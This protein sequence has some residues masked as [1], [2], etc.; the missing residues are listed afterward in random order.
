MAKPKCSA[1]RDKLHIERNEMTLQVHCR[2]PGGEG[3]RPELAVGLRSSQQ[4]EFGRI[5]NVGAVAVAVAGIA[6]KLF[7]KAT[8]YSTT[9]LVLRLYNR[10][11]HDLCPRSV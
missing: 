10:L 1:Y 3:L 5:R 11:V 7:R 4:P 9:P 2:C 6:L 8:P